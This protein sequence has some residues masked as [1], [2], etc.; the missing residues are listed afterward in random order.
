VKAAVHVAMIFGRK[1]K[2]YIHR[3]KVTLKFTEL[4]NLS[5]W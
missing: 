2:Y 3:I 4:F 1:C 5:S